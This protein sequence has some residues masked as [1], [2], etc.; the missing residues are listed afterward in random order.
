[1]R[2]FGR[3]VVAFLAVVLVS[4]T[5]SAQTRTFTATLNAAAEVPPSNSPG[6]GTATVTLNPATKVISWTV[7]YSGLGEPVMA[8]HIHGPAAASA[9]ASVVVPLGDSLASPIQ[10]T[11]SL[12][13]G[14]IADLEAGKYYVMLH[15]KSHPGGAIRGQL[16]P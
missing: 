13:D 8:A 4:G 10:G 3:W 6:T 11:A 5:A 2:Q 1:M 16:L 12:T 7:T 14:Q 15:T 9:N